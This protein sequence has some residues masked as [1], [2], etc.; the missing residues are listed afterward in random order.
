[1]GDSRYI[2][3]SR[4]QVCGDQYVNSSAAQG[5]EDLESGRWLPLGVESGHVELLSSQ[6][7]CHLRKKTT[8]G[9][10]LL[11]SGACRHFRKP[12]IT[13]V[14]TYIYIYLGICF[15]Y[16]TSPYPIMRTTYT[17]FSLS[18]YIRLYCLYEHA[19]QSTNSNFHFL[20]LKW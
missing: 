12:F 2:D 20:E 19:H 9:H 8:A 3:P 14:H 15:N 16:R 11:F 1:M 17:V 18:I 6:Q 10:L 5:L 13:Y 7:L 4:R